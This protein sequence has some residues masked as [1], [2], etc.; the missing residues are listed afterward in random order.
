MHAVE[1]SCLSV[2]LSVCMFVTESCVFISCC[3]FFVANKDV[4]NE[5]SISIPSIPISIPEPRITLTLSLSPSCLRN[6]RPIPSH[7]RL[8]TGKLWTDF[9]SKLSGRITAGTRVTAGTE[10]DPIPDPT[11]RLEPCYGSLR[12]LDGRVGSNECPVPFSS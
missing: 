7:P 8:N 1:S 5:K 11:Q 10:S 2:C 9:R 12:L 6:S 4:Y 3:A